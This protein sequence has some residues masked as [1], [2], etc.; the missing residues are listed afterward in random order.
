MSDS[1]DRV[2]VVTGGGSGIGRQTALTLA[3]TMRVAVCDLDGEAAERTAAVIRD[4]GGRAQAHQ[5]DV[6][7]ADEVARE[8]G[9]AGAHFGRIDV[10]VASGGYQ[11][12]LGIRDIKS[13]QWDRMLAVHARG[14]FNVAQSCID[15]MA[16]HHYGRIVLVSSMAATGGTSPHYSA[17][18]AAMIGFA[19]S[20]C[21]EV[22][23]LGI[24]ANVVAPGAIDTPMLAAA[25][26]AIRARAA[27]NPMGRMGTAEEVADAIE[28]L[29][30]ERAGFITGAVL[31]INGGA[32][33]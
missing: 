7:D 21:R 11:D 15:F 14:A 27:G 19:K 20:L 29:A 31:H 2:A 22:G 26:E 32:H 5:F 6:A 16:A 25:T 24:T 33:T 17:A 18:K 13:E 23:P 4:S 9:A 12:F 1:S 28:F 8:I 30:S 10:A 3:R